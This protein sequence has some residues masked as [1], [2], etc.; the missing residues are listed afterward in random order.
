MNSY[1]A[2]EKNQSPHFYISSR[3]WN[4]ALEI[5]LFAKGFEFREVKDIHKEGLLLGSLHKKDSTLT[6]FLYR[7]YMSKNLPLRTIR[8]KISVVNTIESL[9]VILDTL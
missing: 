1:V 9:K 5:H 4:L 7:M 3:I 6:S 8:R 2:V